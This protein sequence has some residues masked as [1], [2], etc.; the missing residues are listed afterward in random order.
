MKHVLIVVAALLAAALAG[1]SDSP[2]SSGD[3]AELLAKIRGDE[4]PP[5]T[6]GPHYYD[7]SQPWHAAANIEIAYNNRDIGGYRKNVFDADNFTFYFSPA[8]YNAGATPEQWGHADEIQSATKMFTR[9][10]D[11]NGE[12]PIL[13][14]SLELYGVDQATWTNVDAPAEFPGE[15]WKKAVI[16]YTFEFVTEGDLTYIPQGTPAGEFTVR[17]VDGEWRL[18]EWRDLAGTFRTGMSPSATEE[19]TWGAVKARYH[20]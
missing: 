7:L 15:T 13:R 10:P 18:V 12:H 6:P 14:I 1:C 8:D 11:K 16:N 2:T 4:P 20:Y 9:Q 3:F 17:Q 19:T 5:P